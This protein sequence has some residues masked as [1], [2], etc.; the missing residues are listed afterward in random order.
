MLT[1]KSTKEISLTLGKQGFIGVHKSLQQISL[2]SSQVR[3]DDTFRL[4]LKN[5]VPE[6]LKNI[7]PELENLI[8]LLMLLLHIFLCSTQNI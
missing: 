8:S 4:K 6:K 2:C 1:T 5:I 7:V 3:R